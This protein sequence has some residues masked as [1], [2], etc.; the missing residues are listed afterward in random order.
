LRDSKRKKFGKS[1]EGTLW[2][3]V[4]GESFFLGWETFVII[5]DS[6]ISLEELLSKKT[7]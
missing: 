4:F 2:L 7:N 5:L 6:E 3:T 1:N